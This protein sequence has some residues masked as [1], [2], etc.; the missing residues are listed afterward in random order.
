MRIQLCDP[1]ARLQNSQKFASYGV[2]LIQPSLR[3]NICCSSF[4]NFKIRSV[5]LVSEQWKMLPQMCYFLCKC[6]LNTF[7]VW[8][9]SNIGRSIK[10]RV[11][12]LPAIV[13]IQQKMGLTT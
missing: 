2:V 12:D 7:F 5:S 3:W 10:R 6:Y 13:S 11:A 1:V 4:V 8:E 9:K